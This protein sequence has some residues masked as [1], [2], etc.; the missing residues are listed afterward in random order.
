[1]DAEHR[2]VDEG[3]LFA[4]QAIR[5]EGLGWHGRI[6]LSGIEPDTDRPMVAAQLQTLLGMGLRNLGKTKV[7]ARVDGQAA[8]APEPPDI[9]PGGRFIITLQTPALMIPPEADLNNA[10]FEEEKRLNLYKAYWT[11]LDPRLELVRFFASQSL[12]G[13]YLGHR[14]Q[15]NKAYNPFL[16]TMDGSV[17]ALRT[18][19]PAPYPETRKKLVEWMRRGLPLPDWTRQY[20]D[21]TGSVSWRTCPFVPENGF[22]EIAVNLSCHND[23]NPPNCICEVIG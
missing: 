3:K 14:F 19:E 1:M 6:D 21:E 13:G 9:G 16:L 12:M 17:F 15:K 5:P 20:A 2:R 10:L 7:T 23:M 4:Y 18:L 11:S 8:N 22:G